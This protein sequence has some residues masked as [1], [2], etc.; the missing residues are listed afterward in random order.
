MKVEG[1]KQPDSEEPDNIFDALGLPPTALPDI[2]DAIL[3][4]L[5]DDL[6]AELMEDRRQRAEIEPS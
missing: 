5:P 4:I 1:E 2:E 6:V 3:E